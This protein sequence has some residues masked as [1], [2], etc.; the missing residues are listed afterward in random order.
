MFDAVNKNIFI[1]KLSKSLISEF[2]KV[3][4]SLRQRPLVKSSGYESQF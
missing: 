2:P 1:C 4:C 3:S